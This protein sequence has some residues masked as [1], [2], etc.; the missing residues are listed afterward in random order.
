[1][2][3]NE[4]VARYQPR[5]ER[6]PKMKK[7]VLSIYSAVVALMLAVMLVVPGF[8][9]VLNAYAETTEEA[10]TAVPAATEIPAEEP[11]EPM[12]GS[13]VLVT[14]GDEQ[15]TVDDAEYYAYLLY[16]YGYTEEY[17]DYDAAIDYLVQQSV[18]NKH[19][20]EAGYDQFSEEEQ[21]AFE[22]EA[23][24]EFETMLN[25]YVDNY[26]TEDTEENRTT[27]R[28]QAVEYYNSL[29]YSQ[30][31][32][33]EELMLT[34]A[35]SRLEADLSNNYAPTDEEV[36]DVFQLYGAQY[37]QQYEGN[38][39]MYEYYTQYNG[40]ESW[41]VPEGYRSVIHILLDVEE[42]QLKAFLDAQSAWEE[43]SSDENADA[44]ALAAAKIALDE[45]RAAVIASRQDDIDA[46]YAAL[47]Q[48]ESFQ[49]LIAAY[50]TDPGMQ[51]EATLA[52]GYKV[53]QDSIIYDSAFTEGAFQEKMQ[54]IGDVSDPVVS[55]FGIHILYYLIA[56]FVI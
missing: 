2:W 46:I 34:E 11:A 21:K 9:N 19:L 26:L 37:K 55:Q 32:I 7:K 25:D 40:Y 30:Q 28:E 31:N 56:Y 29:D 44:D 48:G 35:R 24:A 43:L 54:K 5:M 18:I 17:P 49:N 52:A 39:A 15:I 1:M 47:E 38:V 33:A 13:I 50:G 51:D 22:N 12:D 8:V 53:H 4:T 16:Y 45:A 23:A 3:H 6:K 10:P 27:L 20:H 42:E 14:V 41:Y 36:D